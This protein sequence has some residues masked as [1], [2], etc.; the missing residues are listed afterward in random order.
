MLVG[1]KSNENVAMEKESTE[2]LSLSQSQVPLPYVAY[3]SVASRTQWVPSRKSPMPQ[4]PS[5]LLPS[6][7]HIDRCIII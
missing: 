5:T 4:V 6:S 7:S 1:E 2:V 3:I